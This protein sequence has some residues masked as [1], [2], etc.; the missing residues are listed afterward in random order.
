MYKVENRIVD[1][2]LYAT[3]DNMRGRCLRPDNKSYG[4]Y[5]GRG[6]TICERWMTFWNF[7][8][9]M[10]DRQE[11]M[12]LDR[13]DNDGQYSPENC[14]WATR[15]K[16]ARNRRDTVW[17]VI[18]GVKHSAAD[19]ADIAGVKPETIARR[20]KAGLSYEQIVRPTKTASGGITRIRLRTHCFYGHE[21]TEKNLLPRKDGGYRCR[22]CTLGRKEKE[23]LLAKGD[24]DAQ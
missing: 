21:Y 7:A 12:T 2:P 4:N 24:G 20:H 13:R 1:H 17:V 16:Q 14:Y 5:G 8:E 18:D 10:G 23:K 15:K 9:D 11:G 6:I 3:W 19:L 22:A